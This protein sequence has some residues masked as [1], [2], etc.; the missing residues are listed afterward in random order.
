MLI[1]GSGTSL[2]EGGIGNDSLYGGGI[3]AAYQGIINNL[4]AQVRAAR[5]RAD[6][7]TSNPMMTWLRS[8]RPATTS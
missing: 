2:L 7:A 4:A 3:P 1:G 5:S 8:S 6:K